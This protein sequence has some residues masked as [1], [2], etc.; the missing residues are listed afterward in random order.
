MKMISQMK[1]NV[2]WGQEQLLAYFNES[3]AQY[4]AS[5]K[6][7]QALREKGSLIIQSYYQKRMAHWD[8]SRESELIIPNIYLEVDISI[9]GKIDMIEPKIK[10]EVIVYDFKTGKPKSRNA[11]L[12]LTRAKNKDYYR[13][14]VFYKLLL[15]LY[16]KGQYTMTE[17]VIEF[18]ESAI[19]G[20]VKKESF[21]I[22]DKE[23]TELIQSIRDMKD[24]ILN[25]TFW[26]KRCE[27]LDCEY[28]RLRQYFYRPLK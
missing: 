15:S 22:E 25:L 13:Q 14:L 5:E 20:D 17:G 3:I 24:S 18:V 28:C 16:K 9:N 10:N 26:D 1:K 12:G 8:R 7:L 27:D 6:D 11:L 21:V 4:P 2:L 23:V 19:E